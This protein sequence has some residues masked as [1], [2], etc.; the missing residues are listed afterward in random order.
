MAEAATAAAEAAAEALRGAADDSAV[1]A[2]RRLQTLLVEA[3][4]SHAQEL[5]RAA[6]VRVR[7]C[8]CVRVSVSERAEDSVL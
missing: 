6:E 5:Q 2:D 4:A 3:T 8:V 1:D 7:E